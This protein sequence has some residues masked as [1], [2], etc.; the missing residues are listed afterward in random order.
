MRLAHSRPDWP[1]DRRIWSACSSCRLPAACCGP[2][3]TRRWPP[4]TPENPRSPAVW[5]SPRLPPWR[6]HAPRPMRPPMPAPAGMRTPGS[7]LSNP[8]SQPDDRRIHMSTRPLP[9]ALLATL[10]L[11][12]TGIAQ[13]A[14]TPADE[15]AIEQQT[16]QDIGTLQAELARIE[17]ERQRL[18][19]QLAGSGNDNAAQIEQLSTQ[20]IALRDRLAVMEELVDTQRSEE[21][22]KWFTVGGATVALSLLAGW[23]LGRLGGGRKRNMW[24]N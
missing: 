21:Q 16:E 14:D 1:P 5:E 3:P 20:N 22:R 4:T 12:Q 19:D 17:A 8:Y 23:L 18:A 13:S 11:P 10:W 9:L 7:H 15:S 24:L 6:P 2:A